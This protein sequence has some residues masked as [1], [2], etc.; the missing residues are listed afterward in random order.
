MK[1]NKTDL[2]GAWRFFNGEDYWLG[3]FTDKKR[4]IIMYKENIDIFLINGFIEVDGA[5]I[6][7]IDYLKEN[8]IKQV[9]DLLINW[10]P[11]DLIFDIKKKTYLVEKTAGGKRFYGLKEQID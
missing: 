11:F 4:V 5:S 8:S 10:P 3:I 6:L 1:I 2:I 9:K 7:T